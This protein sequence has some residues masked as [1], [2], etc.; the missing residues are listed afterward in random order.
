MAKDEIKPNIKICDPAC[1]VGK[2]L[3][4]PI[5]SRLNEFYKTDK[6]GLS[7]SITICGFDKGFD[8]DEQKTIILAKANMLIYFSDFPK[9]IPKGKPN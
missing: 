4:E 5:K 7:K 1:G 2:F 6:N 3:L 8:K 9:G